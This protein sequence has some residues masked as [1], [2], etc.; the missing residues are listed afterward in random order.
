MKSRSRS[1]WIA[2]AWMAQSL[3]PSISL[4]AA[5]RLDETAG[6]A[7]PDAVALDT[8]VV[9]ARRAQSTL[10]QTPQKIE[11]V[12][13]EDIERSV[14][15]D[16]TDVLKKN[17]SVDVIQFNGMLS[18]VGIRGFRPEFEFAINKRSLLLIDGRPAGSTNL[19]TVLLDNVE[20]IEVQKGPASALYGPSAMGGVVNVITQR[21][22][23]EPTTEFTAGYG[24]FDRK[25]FSTTSAG[26]LGSSAYYGITA[27]RLEQ[28]D[29][30]RTGNGDTRPFT[31]FETNHVTARVGYDLSSA[32]TLEGSGE[33]HQ[34]RDVLSPGSD[35]NGTAQQSSK[36]LDRSSL[37]VR[38]TGEID[39][40]RPTV[41]VYQARERADLFK[42]ESSIAADQPFLPFQQ[43]GSDIDYFGV[44]LRNDWAWS[45]QHNLLLGIDY[46]D[47]ESASQSFGPGADGTHIEE[48]LA[49]FRDNER[50]TTGV[51][52]QSTLRFREGRTVL[53]AGARF[54]R[55]E[56]ETFATPL[57]PT[58]EPS[59]TSTDR[60][61][62]S[63]GFKQE[64]RPGLRLHGTAGRGFVVPEAGQLTGFNR[65]RVGDRDRITQGNP[66]LRFESSDTWDL[67]LEWIGASARLDLTYFA[68]KV[69]D[70]I[71]SVTVF[72]PPPDAPP[73]D[74]VIASFTNANDADIRGIELDAQWQID[75]QAEVFFNWNHYF[76]RSETVGGIRSEIFNIAETALRAGIDAQV[77]ALSGRLS[78]RYV[79]ERIAQDFNQNPVAV[80]AY[81]DFVT[82]DM[83][84]RYELAPQQMVTMDVGNLL[85]EEYFEVLGYTLAGRNLMMRYRY[86]F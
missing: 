7:G 73:E 69:D 40:H 4:H 61:T 83:T 13:H 34:D 78:A 29:D 48:R 72:T 10:S 52:A 24:S 35:L 5:E 60:F 53:D 14:A 19:S 80:V 46:D 47:T 81:P 11:V 86:S 63:I 65:Q 8:V 41:V 28:D 77:G 50:L 42:V 9:T 58:F 79:G 54:D 84:L 85:D 49:F 12:T 38:L 2:A 32:W 17:S 26:G 36:D 30:Y 27:R 6:N 18:G 44:Q 43:F 66:D 71:T 3:A 76:E 45:D 57:A 21:Q 64:V 1:R 68:T 25:E 62:P 74:A 39:R 23:G 20:R 70:R 22:R 75:A 67:G 16:L 59:S 33:F 37:E 82:V 51:F 56:V 31:R 55:I 15:Q